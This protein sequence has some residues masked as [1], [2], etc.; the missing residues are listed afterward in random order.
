MLSL[1][2]NQARPSGRSGAGGSSRQALVSAHDDTTATGGT[3]P[4]EQQ[5]HRY[6]ADPKSVTL[7]EICDTSGSSVE[8]VYGVFEVDGSLTVYCITGRKIGSR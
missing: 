7:Q 8:Y 1:S 3:A 5:T 2:A 4:M 6:F